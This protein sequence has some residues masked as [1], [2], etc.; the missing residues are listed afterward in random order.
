MSHNLF[1]EEEARTHVHEDS[2]LSSRLE[3]ESHI[4]V[5]NSFRFYG[6][7]LFRCFGKNKQEH[8]LLSDQRPKKKPTRKR[9]FSI[10]TG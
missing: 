10:Q 8:G 2:L 5:G 7:L 4:E 9:F 1:G 6:I 3:G